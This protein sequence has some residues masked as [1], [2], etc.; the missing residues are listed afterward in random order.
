MSEG[1]EGFRPPPGLRGAHRQTLAG[2]LLPA[3]RLAGV[4]EVFV[5]VAP[6]TEVRLD[7]QGDPQ[8]DAACL[9]LVHG[10]G[11]S[12][13]SAYMR[14][15]AAQA[16]T[17]GYGVV[18]MNLRNAGGTVARSATLYHAG[19]HEDL[20]VV[21]AWLREQG[22]RRAHLVGF[23]MGGNLSLRAAAL[24]PDALHALLGAVVAVNPA[25]DLQAAVA[26]I[27]SR[28]SLWL[29]RK[30][31]C[32]DLRQLVRERAALQPERYDLGKLRGIRGVFD[33]DERFT[34]PEF[35]FAGAEDY[36]QKATAMPLL[37][38][39]RHP[40]LVIQSADDPMIPADQ[41]EQIRA[42]AGDRVQLV[43]SQHG[44][45]LGYR[46]HRALLADTPFW[47]GARVLAHLRSWGAEA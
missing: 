8:T 44:G 46:H 36:Y 19:L 23:S 30:M 34:A 20:L 22:W 4:R 3:P 5:A 16:R 10:L 6:G 33:F 25:L 32:R 13:D 31:F 11:G 7:I 9:L 27:D 41:V 2:A 18:R 21:L 28:P 35:G 37:G 14:H 26:Q 29:Y 17:E 39:L 1:A 47:A 38:Q 42:R 24:L 12:A 45:H 40:A 15:M 43:L